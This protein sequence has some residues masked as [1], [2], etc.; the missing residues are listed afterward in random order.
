MGVV[1]ASSVTSNRSKSNV[2]SENF[3][4]PP[5]TILDVAFSGPSP[6]SF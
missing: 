6:C 3:V 2:G 4:G 1:T 5:R